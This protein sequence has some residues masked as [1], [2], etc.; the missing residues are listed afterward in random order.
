MAAEARQVEPF[1]DRRDRSIG[2]DGL[3]FDVLGPTK[4]W[5]RVRHSRRRRSGNWHFFSEGRFGFGIAMFERP[6]PLLELLFFNTAAAA[7]HHKAR[8][9]K[10]DQAKACCA[11]N[12]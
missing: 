10:C 5:F 1:R 4:G 11:R 9:R 7:A 3:R 8:A 6:L 2:R 12:G